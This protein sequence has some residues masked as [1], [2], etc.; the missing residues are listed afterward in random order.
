[1]AETRVNRSQGEQAAD[2]F[3]GMFQ[4]E[5]SDR[6]QFVEEGDLIRL[7]TPETEQ[8]TQR[9]T[10]M[11]QQMPSVVD[12]STFRNRVA[13]MLYNHDGSTRERQRVLNL[14]GR[15]DGAFQTS[16]LPSG[17]KL[18]QQQAQRA[19][20]GFD[21]SAVSTPAQ[22]AEVLRAIVATHLAD[23]T[24]FN[25]N[26]AAGSPNAQYNG[27]RVRLTRPETN[28]IMS[29]MDELFAR[30]QSPQDVTALRAAGAELLTQAPND[31]Y[32]RN[33]KFRELSNHFEAA[34]QRALIR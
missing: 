11:V 4:S 7:N 25:V 18:D 2:V 16:L 26:E 32:E 33:V 8:L 9:Y 21:L 14:A 15:L 10:G 5:I 29:L 1:M 31:G 27:E 20:T 24:G 17:V 22:A 19:P 12:R 3:T 28:R 13:T 34:Y 6:E 30:M 23:N